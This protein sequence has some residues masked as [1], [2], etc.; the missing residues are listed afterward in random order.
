MCRSAQ[1][2]AVVG[3]AVPSMEQV[4]ALRLTM[5]VI[6]EAMRLY[7]QPPV[8]IRRALGPDTLAGFRL[9]AGSDLFISVWN[10][11]R[12]A[13]GVAKAKLAGPAH[14]TTAGDV[15][16]VHAWVSETGTPWR[17]ASQCASALTGAAQQAL[18]T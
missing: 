4:R 9:P 18:P 7:P 16:S 1:V 6:N 5:R 3:D 10:L 15:S 12:C 2:D 17:R 8:L 13:P 11:H 14:A